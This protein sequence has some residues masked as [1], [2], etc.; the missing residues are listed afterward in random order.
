MTDHR[1][2]MT[3]NRLPTT[4]KCLLFLTVIGLR[5]SVIGLLDDDEGMPPSN[6]LTLLDSNLLHGTGSG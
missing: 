5:S 1:R 4:G 3:L 2:Q 6:R